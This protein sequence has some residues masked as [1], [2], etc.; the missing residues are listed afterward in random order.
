MKALFH[1][2]FEVKCENGTYCPTR[3]T[4]RQ[5][6][7]LGALNPSFGNFGRCSAGVS[8]VF[9]TDAAEIS[10]AYRYTPLYTR[11]AGFDIYENGVMCK[12]IKLPEDAL[13]DTFTYV[14]ENAGETRIEI[15]LPHNAEMVLWDFNLGNYRVVAPPQGKKILWYGDSITQSAY[16]HTPSLSYVDV[17][18]RALGAD[19]LNR[20]IG[21]LF[22]D[23]SVLDAD[24]PVKPDIIVVELGANDMVKHD[25][26]K[27][28]TAD[29][30][31][32]FS[33]AE[34]VPMLIGNARAYLEK[35]K[36]IY[37]AAKIFVQSL[38]YASNAKTP[39]RIAAQNDYVIA[40][41]QLVGEL[42]LT[43]IDAPQQTPHIPEVHAADGVHLNALGS[44]YAARGFERILAE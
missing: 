43:Y 19:Y 10:F 7:A 20:G 25:G 23:A 2:A 11:V 18:S 39:G 26:G 40:L 13:T 6:A 41:E 37:P 8:L 16:I 3:F 28:V 21:S 36:K 4:D 30:V 17:A 22:Y 33:D 38:F 35:L 24:D 31:V 42:G 1:H 29:G 14:K 5:L 44:A 34:D 15:F 27:V 12:N 32:Q 9:D